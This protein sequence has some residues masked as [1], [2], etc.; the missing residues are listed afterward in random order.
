M[1]AIHKNEHWERLYKPV[2]KFLKQAIAAICLNRRHYRE[3]LKED[4]AFQTIAI[5]HGYSRTWLFNNWSS[6]FPNNWPAAFMLMRHST[7]SSQALIAI[8]LLVCL[9]AWV[10]KMMIKVIR[11]GVQRCYAK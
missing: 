10:V 5:E 7:E 4:K 2:P 6:A 9:P 11:M 1:M 8:V 3:C